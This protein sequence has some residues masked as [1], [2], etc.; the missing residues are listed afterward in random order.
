MSEAQSIA[1]SVC[2]CGSKNCIG[3]SIG[4]KEAPFHI[5]NYL[6]NLGVANYLRKW[7]ESKCECEGLR[8]K[9]KTRLSVIN[10]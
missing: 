10:N 8:L 2:F 7:Y 6:Y 3:K 4:F 1:V 9:V 5:Q